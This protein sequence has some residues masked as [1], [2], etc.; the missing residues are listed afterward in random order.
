ML[1]GS[2]SSSVVSSAPRSQLSSPALGSRPWRLVLG[3]RRSSSAASR[4]QRSS[5]ALG[6]WRSSLVLL[7]SPSSS[8]GELCAEVT[9]VE[10]GAGLAAVELGAA[11]IAVELCCIKVT[12]VKSGT[13]LAG[14]A[15]VFGV[16]R[17]KRGA[18]FAIGGLAL[19]ELGGALSMAPLVVP[20][21]MLVT[22]SST[23]GG[24]SKGGDRFLLLTL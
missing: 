21:N 10:S 19:V 6:S 20:A 13:A 9:A 22:T 12:E 23:L 18:A 7:G 3:L 1:L 5:P 16:E 2:P 4:S 15:F 17:A 11:R 14:L 8:G 24:I